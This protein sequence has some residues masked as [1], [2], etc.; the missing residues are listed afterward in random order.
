M[1]SDRRLDSDA[2]SPTPNDTFTESIID[3]R[4]FLSLSATTGAALALPGSAT[5]DVRGEPM[6]DECAFVVNHTPAEYETP[7]GIEFADQNALET[8][9]D[10]YATAPD[11]DLPRA[12]KAVIRDSPTLAAHA[13][14]TA[15]EVASVLGQDGIERLDFSPGANPWWTLESP[16]A[17]G[18]FPPVE[19][20][21][22]YVSYDELLSGL[23]HLESAHPDRVRVEAIGESP[24]W[25][26]RF[27]GEN[28]DPK[29]IHVA[30]VTANVRDEESFAAKE[31]V[32]YSLSIH[33]D[34]RAGA[35][36]GC[37]LIEDIA[38]GRADDFEP[39][40][41]DVVILFLFPNPDGWVART[42]QTEIPWVE[43]H[44]TNFQRGNASVFDRQPVD[45][46]RQYPTIGWTNPSFRPAE[47]NGAPDEFDDI[48]PDSL[49][50]VDHFRGYDN[51]AFF[52]DYHGMYTADHVVFGLES[53]A[54]FDYGET[55]EFDEI[56]VRN[57]KGMRA[58]WG[59]VGPIEDDIA[60]AIEEMYQWVDDGAK[61]VPDGES[62][63][64]LFDW[65]TIYDSIG[66]QVT[67]SLFGWA[68]QPE[69]FGGL[70]A[71]AMSPEVILSNHRVAAQKEWKPYWSRHYVTAYRTSM[72]ECAETIVREP[73]A[74]VATGGQDTAYVTTDALTRSSADLPHTDTPS[75][76]NPDRRD[77]CPTEVR[78]SSEVVHPTSTGRS[79]VAADANDSSHSLFIRFD[80]V[81]HATEGSIRVTD[82]DGTIVREI[83][84]TAKED[85]TDPTARKHDFED[86]FVRRPRAGRWDI[87]VNCD[88][89]VH[90]DTT[91]IDVDGEIPDPE[92]VLG[93]EQREYAVNPMQF[94][95]DLE[96]YLE[97][98]AMDGVG[99]SQVTAGQLVRDDGTTCRYDTL[100]VSSDA[101]IDQ[102]SYIEA[103]E[104]FV[105]RGGDLV[106]TDA[107]VALLGELDVGA[108]AS[109]E[110]TDVRDVEMLFA[111]LEDRALDHPLLAG[112]RPRQ[113]E[114]WT[115]PQL[116]YTTE[117]DQPATIVDRDAFTAAG[118]SVAGSL[119]GSER[120]GDPGP[121]DSGVGA[122]TLSAGDS[123]ITVLGSV[124]PPAQQ[125]ELHPFGMAD[126][127]LS[128]LGHTLVCNALGF[129][130]RRYDAD[131]ELVR[132][133]GE[134]R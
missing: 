52:C 108:A 107:G 45:T 118:G 96:P 110:P 123:E 100:V 133:Y 8:F 126:Y 39:L 58:H 124:L 28:P 51:V 104:T 44:D 4:T 106:L 86:A 129:E 26:N 83:D 53:N 24:G 122:G 109:I 74:T 105:D 119:S 73:S 78:R 5:A 30:E 90:V 14:L 18:V 115:G 23:D 19:E 42:P 91:V 29:P 84:L 88:A 132:T 72:R 82:P 16:Y 131:G 31:K 2:G 38:A 48:V 17:D 75:V 57:G 67:G 97:D 41:D 62:Y 11:P 102:P 101:G 43:A 66:Y 47:P 128:F 93:Y 37:R 6:T 81:R 61:A 65:G 49:S 121:A 46:N 112:I 68:G 50:I 98:G 95:A 111:V 80:G 36:S 120:D 103:I 9:A 56:C 116:G 70:G 89:D 69:A 113:R 76:R 60:T 27:T 20:A 117:R 1:V 71:T 63:D 64:G 35:E 77:G 114:I 32:V 87:D 99:V 125:T 3:R 7:I 130:Q 33:G 12:P 85:P 127:A 21:R 10:E 34:E 40:L 13:H 59:D 54:S 94:F 15:D 25:S 22:N 79:S 134:I 55:H 92:A